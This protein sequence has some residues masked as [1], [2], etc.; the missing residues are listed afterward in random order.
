MLSRAFAATF[1]RVSDN[2]LGLFLRTRR[3]AVSPADAGLPAGTR[4]RTPGLR[5]AELATLAGVSVEYLIRLEQ[6]RDRH[7]SPSVLAA[8]A[9]ALQ[10]TPNQRVYLYQLAKAAGPGFH[11]LGG[12][13]P[14]RAVR[15]MVRAL[16]SQLEPAAAAISN[17]LG[18]VLACTTGYQLLMEPTGQLDGGLPANYPRY[19]F[20]DPRSREAYPDWDNRADKVVAT[21]KQGPFRSD[22]LVSALIDELTI[23]A[24]D[25]FTRR[26]RSIP[27]LPD[28]H[29]IVRI[30]HPE[31]DQLRLSYERL[32]LSADD[33]QHLTVYLAADE[34]SAAALNR[35]IKR[36]PGGLHVV[37]A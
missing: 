3:E 10:M 5:R 15:P 13:A 35:L 14:N 2:E 18:E 19:L 9:D 26:M 16:L 20:T 36:R 1:E 4:R 27:G 22:S 25:E 6:G 32:D 21:L 31:V 24:G 28:S 29:G 34:A 37:P 8:L 17:R 12:A 30:N 23:R 7:P 11:C 33:D